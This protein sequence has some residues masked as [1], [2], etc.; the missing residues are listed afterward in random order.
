M[1]DKSGQ[2][3]RR[4]GE[5]G[6]QRARI[7][8]Q[9]EQS[10]RKH[11]R[12]GQNMVLC[13]APDPKGVLTLMVPHYFLGN[14]TAG[15][16]SGELAEKEQF[17]SAVIGGSCL[18]SHGEIFSIARRLGV[19]TSFIKLDGVLG[20]D[21]EMLA[22]A[23]AIISSYGISYVSSRA[24]LLFDI[25]EFSL[26]TPFE[27]ASQLNSLSYSMNSAYSKLQRQGV[28]VNF[29]R[30][31]T[32]DGYYV[33]NRDQGAYP[34][35]DMLSF[36]LLILIDNAVARGQASGNTVPVI[37]SAFHIG[38]HYELFQAEGV[39]PSVL[40]YIVGDVTIA[41]ARMLESGRAGQIILGEFQANLPNR[42]GV[43][44]AQEFVAQ[45]IAELKELNKLRIA[46]QSLTDIRA[47]TSQ[48]G[49]LQTLSMVDKHGM[50]LEALN[51]ELEIELSDENLRLGVR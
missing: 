4:Q 46:G 31:T 33:W 9:L 15:E 14:L 47:V 23:D 32:G 48:E 1:V 24:V 21:P 19:S 2:L 12:L 7:L 37:R 34:D 45:A 36:L 38:S 26:Y 43:F 3:R 8:K 6:S 17:V 22:A 20:E 44:G 30:T 16:G 49:A 10:L 35:L 40:S 51:L 11:W 41:L 50:A 28:D 18:K 5:S 13:W 27:Q 42:E 29:A 25:A 39:N